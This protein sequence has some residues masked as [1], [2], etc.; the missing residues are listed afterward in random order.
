[1]ARLIFLNRVIRTGVSMSISKG[2]F[3][4]IRSDLDTYF[5]NDCEL[6]GF[7]VSLCGMVDRQEKKVWSGKCMVTIP[8]KTLPTT[9]S[10]LMVG[11][12]GESKNYVTLRLRKLEKMGL[13]LIKKRTVTGMESGTA[14]LLITI[15]DDG[16]Y[17]LFENDLVTESVTESVTLAGRMRDGERDGSPEYL[18]G[19]SQLKFPRKGKQKIEKEKEKE[20][21]K[22]I[23][24]STTI[25]SQ[26]PESRAPTFLDPLNDV[27][28]K[29]EKAKSFSE[30]PI[31]IQML[32]TNWKEHAN[33]I[34]PNRTWEETK[35]CEA[36]EK[37][38]KSKSLK[39]TCQELMAVFKWAQND[40]FWSSLII[41]PACLKKTSKNGLTKL[42]NIL[43]QYHKGR[44]LDFDLMAAAKK[45]SKGNVSNVLKI[46]PEAKS[47]APKYNRELTDK[48]AELY[49]YYRELPKGVY[50]VN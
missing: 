8:A 37:I 15:R 17:R 45:L 35:F 22:E 43:T 14:S 2:W 44:K 18:N 34:Q 33:K 32:A 42:D 12:N 11:L 41:S 3:K 21:E 28:I 36:I 19:S 30:Y 31:D 39:I 5:K 23:E 29:K 25:R 9:L 4:L 38:I 10:K 49:Y 24:Q 47:E 13:I 48:E 16:E 20:T 40:S 46:D 27:A 6:L 1:M 26:A 50:R 7:Y